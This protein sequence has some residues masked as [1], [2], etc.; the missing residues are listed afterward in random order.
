MVCVYIVHYSEQIPVGGP[1][2]FSGCLV[3]Y[4]Y[5]L[6]VGA[7]KPNCPTH[8]FRLP[9]R[10]LTIPGE[11]MCSSLPPPHLLF[12]FFTVSLPSSLPCFFFSDALK[13]KE[14]AHPSPKSTNPFLVAEEKE[15]SDLFLECAHQALAME[16]S[17]KTS[18][19]CLC[20][21]TLHVG[22]CNMVTILTGLNS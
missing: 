21:F 5:K 12:H 11:C 20:N 10:V 1:P 19:E 15:Y 7:Q 22:G 18:S 14:Y 6:T 9:F 13:T 17:R 2:S 3:R 8:L 4:S 16:T